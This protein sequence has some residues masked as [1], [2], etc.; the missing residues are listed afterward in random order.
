VHARVCRLVGALAS[1]G[2]VGLYN[3][4]L[5]HTPL[6]KILFWTAIAGT[7]LG[8]TQLLLVTGAVCAPLSGGCP[9]RLDSIWPA[10]G[11]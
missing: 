7:V 4:K 2:G 3:F 9:G 1:L 6:R 10:R 8:L 11:R 5:K